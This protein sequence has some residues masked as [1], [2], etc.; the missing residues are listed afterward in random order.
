M[1]D[2]RWLAPLPTTHLLR[3]ASRTG[4]VLIAD[5][6]RQHGGV[7]EAIIAALIDG[8]FTGPIRRATS[9]NSFIPLGTAAHH[10]LLS[11]EDIEKTATEVLN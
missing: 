11:E 3:E 4:R 5:E 10:V 7:S 2:L 1:L 6:T 8:G 9:T